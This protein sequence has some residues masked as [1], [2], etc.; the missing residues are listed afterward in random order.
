MNNL[1]SYESKFMQFMLTVADYI[2]L[3]AI[4]IACCIPIFT[5]GAAQAGLY[6]GLKVLQDKEDDSS[7]L[8]AFFRGF[9]NGFGNITIVWCITTAIIPILAYVILSV[10]V[11]KT[12][13]YVGTT[14]PLIM[15]IVA[16]AIAMIYQSVLTI[17]HSRFSC[18]KRQLVRNVML[19]ILAN[20][21]QSILLG[22]IHWAPVILLAVQYAIFMQTS[23]IF[24]L[25]YYSVALGF[26]MRLFE[27]CFKRLSEGFKNS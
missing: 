5:I 11:F 3:N 15:S 23:L 25:M 26:G 13:E 8:K 21:L 20:P 9:K 22:V 24:L 2:I 19:V 27:K 12:I 10:Y 16:T 17:F 6:S 18:T 1:F 14:V 4:Y 7:P